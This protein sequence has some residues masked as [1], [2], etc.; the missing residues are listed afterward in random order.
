MKEISPSGFL[1]TNKKLNVLYI[2]RYY[3]ALWKIYTEVLAK[4]KSLKIEVINSTSPEIAE[5]K[6]LWECSCMVNSV[7]SST[8]CWYL[9]SLVTKGD[10]E[11]S[12]VINGFLNLVPSVKSLNAV[13]K[14][15][16]DLLVLQVA[17]AVNQ[18]QEYQC[19][20]AL[21]RHD[22][23]LKKTEEKEAVNTT[24]KIVNKIDQC[25]L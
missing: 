4:K 13:V 6:L 8:A 10:A 18:D 15:V 5:L 12:Y 9:V 1:I 24:Q 20:Y 7:V 14:A 25:A 2:T 3:D 21:S 22:I 23:D 16:S 17:L 19:P 11:F